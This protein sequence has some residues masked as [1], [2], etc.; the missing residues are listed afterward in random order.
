MTDKQRQAIEAHGRNLLAIFS[1]A[2]ERDPVALCKKLRR[3]EAKAG[4]IAL[5]LCNGPEWE[6]EYGADNACNDVLRKVYELLGNPK[7][8]PVFINRDPRGYSLKIDDNWMR[9]HEATLHRDM[10]GYGILAPEFSGKD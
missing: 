9:L 1:N 2:T 4:A 3:L 6:L 5:R 7:R 10:G 8:V